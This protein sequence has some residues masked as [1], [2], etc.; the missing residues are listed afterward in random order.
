M[1]MVAIRAMSRY[2]RPSNIGVEMADDTNNNDANIVIPNP[3]AGGGF[4]FEMAAMTLLLGHWQK[5]LAAV[6][7]VLI[8]V[9]AYGQYLSLIHI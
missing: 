1:K 5:I 6:I 2:R 8:F 7:V 3:D 4:K 9:G